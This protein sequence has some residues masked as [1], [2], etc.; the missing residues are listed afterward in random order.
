MGSLSTNSQVV[1]F[2]IGITLAVL[3]I[4]F[5]FLSIKTL[6]PEQRT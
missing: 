1:V 2:L 6:I 4:V 5:A 3:L